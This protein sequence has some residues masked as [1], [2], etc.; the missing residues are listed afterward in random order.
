MDQRLEET[1]KLRLLLT[2]TLFAFV[3]APITQAQETVDVAKITCEQLLMQRLPAP[4]HEVVVWIS[5][6]YNGKR[7]NM[8]LELQTIKDD[9]AKLNTYCFEHRETP[10][11][12][13]AKDVGLDK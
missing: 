7:N 4:S 11:V 1:M 3:Q 2:S 8:I 10:V 13:A 5:G 9:E 12:D 6:Y